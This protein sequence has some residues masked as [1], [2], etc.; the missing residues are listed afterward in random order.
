MKKI[1]LSAL[2]STLLCL[3]LSAQNES[4]E[5]GMYAICDGAP[6]EMHA[7]KGIAHHSGVS[8]LGV[9]LGD[10][11]YEYKGATSKIQASGEFLMVCDST[12]AVVY[13]A[14]KNFNPCGKT[15]TPDNIIIVPLEVVK[16]KNRIY[17]M[18]ETING[19]NT[20]RKERVEF[21]WE[22]VEDR[23]YLISCDPEPG[24]YCIVFRLDRLGKYEY[25]RVF[26]FTIPAK[27]EAAPAQEQP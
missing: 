14:F 23:T 15:M 11:K 18:G 6:V 5:Y 17:D 25:S 4:L 9:D 13:N 21:S 1:I 20:A 19:F 24:E 16:N 22:Q 26:D 12:V 27:A 10:T 7:V 2:A 3:N 8:V